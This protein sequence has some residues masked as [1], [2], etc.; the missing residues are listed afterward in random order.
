MEPAVWHPC[1]QVVSKRH[2]CRSRSGVRFENGNVLT[3]LP[4]FDGPHASF[5]PL[6]A[7]QEPSGQLRSGV[8]DVTLPRGLVARRK[9]S[10]D[11]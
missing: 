6:T 11:A 1:R 10:C 5:T 7:V 8:P 4:H 9:V 2:S 3:G